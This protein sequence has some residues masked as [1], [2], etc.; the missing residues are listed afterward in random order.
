MPERNDW[1]FRVYGMKRSGHHAIIMWLA[2]HFPIN[3]VHFINDVPPFLDP[4]RFHS[5]TCDTTS[6]SN[7]FV[8]RSESEIVG[9]RDLHKLCLIYNYEEPDLHAFANRH[10]VPRKIELVGESKKQFNILV[11]RD[12]FNL[13]ASRWRFKVAERRALFMATLDNWVSYAR[14]FIGDTNFLG[15]KLLVNYNSWFCSEAYRRTLADQVGVA[16]TDSGLN[17]VCANGAGSS[18]DGLRFD[19][20]AQE[21][22][23]LDRWRALV[24]VPPYANLFRARNDV[25]HL[26]E[27]IF[28][29][30]PGT[31]ILFD[32]QAEAAKRFRIQLRVPHVHGSAKM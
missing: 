13:A 22:E 31:E 28:G 5:N 20:N 11:L 32:V 17:R 21:M 10:P 23:V 24:P 19:R 1:E 30:L 12:P 14:E 3:T 27:K 6:R 8:N 29:Y 4:F 25:R 15:P 26:T 2:S 18:W 9:E 7:H 16:F